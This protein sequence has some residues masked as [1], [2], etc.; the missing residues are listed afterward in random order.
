MH[1]LLRYGVP[2]AAFVLSLAA[3][4]TPA[5]SLH[6]VHAQRTS[7]TASLHDV[8]THLEQASQTTWIAWAVPTR[9]GVTLGV[10]DDS[11]AYLEHGN[12]RNNSYHHDTRHPEDHAVL[13]LR[14][15]S[16][17][18]TELRIESPSRTLDAADLPVV[19]LNG[20]TAEQSLEDLRSLATENSHVRDSLVFAISIHNSPA[21]VPT[22][23]SLTSATNPIDLREK[24]CF[25]LGNSTDPRPLPRCSTSPAPILIRSSARNFPL[26][27]HCRNRLPRSRSSFAWLT[28][29]PL[30]R[31]A[32]RHSSGWRMLEAAAL[33]PISVTPPR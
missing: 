18:L 19:E 25:W 15:A 24:A 11:V 31:F 26:I 21:T 9:A 22:L 1:F 30:P 14:V 32:N 28:K 5:K 8:V 17:S 29:I 13:L 23:T 20:I 10:G 16:R 3:P 12:E 27:S 33:L 2:L 4:S 7:S 6:L